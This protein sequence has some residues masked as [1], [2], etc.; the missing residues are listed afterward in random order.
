MAMEQEKPVTIEE[1]PCEETVIDR[2]TFNPRDCI[3]RELRERVRRN[4]YYSLRAFARDMGC[5][6]STLIA[7]IQEE[8]PITRRTARLVLESFRF[9]APEE[10][11]EF[12]KMTL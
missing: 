11:E 2:T 9:L 4:R 3:L 1:N 5:S 10:S 8:R 12:R 7:I 6:H